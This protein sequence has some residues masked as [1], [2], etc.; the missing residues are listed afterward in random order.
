[1][2]S[3]SDIR[4]VRDAETAARERGEWATKR[5][6]YLEEAVRDRDAR[7]AELEAQLAAQRQ[8]AQVLNERRSAD[9]A[10]L[11]VVRRQVDEERAR[12]VDLTRQVAAK[13][14]EEAVAIAA[15]ADSKVLAARLD[16]RCAALQSRQAS[17]QA[18]DQVEREAIEAERR[19]R[20]LAKQADDIEARA[21]HVV[22]EARVTVARV[23]TALADDAR[24][25]E[26]S[27]RVD[28]AIARV[29]ALEDHI[30]STTSPRAWWAPLENSPS[31]Q[32]RTLS[33]REACSFVVGDD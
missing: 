8:A 3:V 18:I 17:S 6:A 10:S 23:R 9:V 33:L 5:C 32:L 16:E 20:D 14:N 4:A 7:V 13:R 28:W 27:D 29:D 12:A 26:L 1:M 22:H 11:A 2:V 31:S 30:A 21:A 15:A 24:D 25:A 19:A